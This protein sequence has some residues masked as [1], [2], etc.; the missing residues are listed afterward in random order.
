[1]CGPQRNA[2]PF[3]LEAGSSLCRDGFYVSRR[4]GWEIGHRQRHEDSVPFANNKRIQ[5]LR[6]RL[7]MR[8]PAVRL[9][10]YL[11]LSSPSASTKP[12]ADYIC[13]VDFA[14]LNRAANIRCYA[15]LGLA[16]A[17]IGWLMSL[18][19]ALDTAIKLGLYRG[20]ASYSYGIPTFGDVRP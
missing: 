20:I 1:V 19:M 6:P 11:V 18:S 2:R 9:F 13:V 17:K 10:P 12:A 5:P 16:S 14:G 4:L 7:P 3:P 8:A 15:S